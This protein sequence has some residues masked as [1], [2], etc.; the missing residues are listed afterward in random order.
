MPFL[1][2][3]L[4]GLDR[5]QFLCGDFISYLK[6]APPFDVVIASG[7]LYHMVNPVEFLQLVSKGTGKL[8]IWTHYYDAAIISNLSGVAHRMPDHQRTS[9]AGFAHTLHRYEYLEALNVHFA[10]GL[11]PYSCW[12]ER[13]EILDCLRYF[14]FANIRINFEDR[15]HPHGPCF[16]MV[17]RR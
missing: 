1:L 16:A 15:D 2:L 14:G 8:F 17:A 9:F 7:V 4:F 10:G 5:V 3:N 12:M 11:C 13:Q 6:T